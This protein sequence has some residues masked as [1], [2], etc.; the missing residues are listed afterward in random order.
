MDESGNES[1]KKSSGGRKLILLLAAA[2]FILILVA[3]AVVLAVLFYLGVFSPTTTVTKRCT[4]PAGFTCYD[5]NFDGSGNFNLDLGQAI[6]R[7]VIVTGMGCEEIGQPQPI[8][9]PNQVLIESASH[10]S[11]TGGDSGNTL[12]CCQPGSGSCRTHFAIGYKYAGSNENRVI[13]GDA[14]GPLE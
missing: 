11:V 13:Y 1:E 12:N 4:T 8:A 14:S 10:K 3:G 9:F 7:D 5:Y 6:G 2:A